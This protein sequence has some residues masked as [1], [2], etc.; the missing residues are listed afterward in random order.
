VHLTLTDRRRRGSLRAVRSS[1]SLLLLAAALLGGCD[2]SSAARPEKAPESEAA[3]PV[4][5]AYGAGVSLDETVSI[6]ALLADPRAFEGKTVRVEGMVTDV[7]PKRGCW[8]DLAGS[9]PG[10]KVRFKVQDGMM[11]FPME[12]KGSTAVAQG[13]VAVKQ[14]TLEETRSY[15]EYQAREYGAA[16]DPA[17]ITEPMLMVRIDGTGAI[18]RE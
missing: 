8:M 1:F 11:T 18:I 5:T 12:A 13:T 6:D 9:G 2:K 16:I 4:G 17:S 7:C 15:A 10:Q 14:M 3:A